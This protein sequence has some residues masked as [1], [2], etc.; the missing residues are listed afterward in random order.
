MKQNKNPSFNKEKELLSKKILVFGIDEVGRGSFAGPIVASAVHFKKEY[1]W[2]NEINDSKLLTPRKREHLSKLILKNAVCFV[3]LIDV[4]I[5]NEFGIGKANKLIFEN[6]IKKIRKEYKDKRIYFLIDGRRLDLNLEDVE[7]IVKGD[8]KSISIAASSIV[9]KVYRDKLMK[10]LG[11]K[12]SGY[13]FSKN[14]GYGT[15]FHQKAIKKLGLSEIH[16]TSFNLQ[17]FLS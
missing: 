14:K 12:Y 16:R 13:A 15:K 8:Q 11:K 17:K 3:E 5:I 4:A 6:L 7:F 2:F 9:A 10:N 1:S